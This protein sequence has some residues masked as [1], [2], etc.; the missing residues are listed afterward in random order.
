VQEAAPP[1]EKDPGAQ[2]AHTAGEAPLPAV[3][4]GQG[5]QPVAPAAGEYEPEHAEHAALPA[6]AA[7]E[8]AAQGTHADGELA[9]K[10]D[11]A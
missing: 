11:D 8:P 3:P 1:A 4:G 7:K 10:T 2:A 6:A 9:P 5:V